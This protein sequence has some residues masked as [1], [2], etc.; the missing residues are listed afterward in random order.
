MSHRMLI[1]REVFLYRPYLPSHTL[2]NFR[3]DNT[4]KHHLPCMLLPL[5]MIN[6]FRHFSNNNTQN[7]LNILTLYI[8]LFLHT[9]RIFLNC[10]RKKKII[11]TWCSLVKY[12][13]FP[14]TLNYRMT[15]ICFNEKFFN[16]VV[17]YILKLISDVNEI[18][19]APSAYSHH[20][21]VILR[22]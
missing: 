17:K 4:E 13:N 3:R 12:W 11:I 6:S 20:Q 8:L 18:V 1:I 16:K 14:V 7:C 21:D 22:L 15:N 5:K 19:H 9:L 10:L 2:L